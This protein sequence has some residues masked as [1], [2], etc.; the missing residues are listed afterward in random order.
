MSTQIVGRHEEIGRSAMRAARV[1]VMVAVF[2]M[3]IDN[4]PIAAAA[5]CV[6]GLAG[7]IAFFAA[8][9]IEIDNGK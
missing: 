4:W 3:V 9:R 6:V 5:G 7:T 8:C 2:G 1:W